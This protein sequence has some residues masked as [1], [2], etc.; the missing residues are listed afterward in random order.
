[1]CVKLPERNNRTETKTISEPQE[2]RRFLATPGI[3]G[4]NVIFSS[5]EVV[6]GSWRFIAEEKVELTD[7]SS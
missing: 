3:E 7:F 1:M 2:L 4:M 5:D 6:W